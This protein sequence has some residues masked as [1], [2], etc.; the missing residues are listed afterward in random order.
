MNFGL[1]RIHSLLEALDRPDERTQIVHVAGTNGKGSVCAYIASVLRTCGYTVGRFN[2]PHLIEP[3]DS[4][5]VNGQAISQ[6][7][8]DEAF[9]YVHQLN[10]KGAIGASSF[11]CLVGA[12]FYV[13]DKVKLDFVVLEVGLGGLLDATNAIRHPAMTVITAIGLDHAHILGHTVEEIASAK[14]GIMKSGCPVVI[15][16]QDSSSVLD[17][18]IHH[19]D[20]TGSP[21]TL[22]QPSE[23]IEPN[24]CQLDFDH[25]HYTY[26]IR[27]MGDYQRMNSATAVTA[28]D[29]MYRLKLIQMTPE[30]LATGM[31]ETRW[32]G[33]LDWVNDT[34][35]LDN[36]GLKQILVDGAHNPPATIALR[37]YIDSLDRK[38]VVWIIG[39]T[40]GKDL[41]EM[42]KELIRKEDVVYAVA[43]SQPDGM[44][45]IKSSLP[46]DIAK[47]AK[48][49][50]SVECC[51]DLDQALVKAGNTCT[52]SDVA[53]LCGSLYLVADLYRKLSSPE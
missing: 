22:V 45:W 27:L 52:D 32:P 37:K 39:S 16:P 2:S 46:S 50:Q 30:Q 3:R 11:E 41:H 21:Y 9:A 49:A 44:P 1:E 51:A 19:A 8:Y 5:N 14:A 18:L 4:I 48:V 26:P 17:T 25:V 10:T 53:V 20:K 40:A 6:S 24:V 38:R 13:F 29:W 34:A 31:K 15:A 23:F 7:L 35:L 43:F 42:M 36:Y 47:E 33:R 12:A 28:L